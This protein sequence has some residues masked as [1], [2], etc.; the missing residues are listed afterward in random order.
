[1]KSKNLGYSLKN[2]T[3]TG[4]KLL[5]CIL[6]IAKW[7]LVIAIV[8]RIMK[9]IMRKM[10]S[11]FFLKE[12]LIHLHYIFPTLYPNDIHILFIHCILLSKG[13]LLILKITLQNTTNASQFLKK[14]FTC[15][16]LKAS[17]HLAYL[18]QEEFQTMIQMLYSM[19]RKFF[20]KYDG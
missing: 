9:K 2:I 14:T 17:L 6:Q 12:N 11:S 1:M 18:L 5:L 13:V 8:M 19:E 3:I 15:S 10:W 4:F 16:N 7:I 20:E